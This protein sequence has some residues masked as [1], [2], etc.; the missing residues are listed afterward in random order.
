[1]SGAPFFNR[2]RA[3]GIVRPDDDRWAAG[4]AA[5][6]ARRWNVHPA[7]VRIGFV[8]LTLLG[9]FGVPLYGLG[10]LFLPHPD[11]R[12]HAQQVLLGKVTAGFFGAA[13][14]ILLGAPDIRGPWLALLLL[15]LLVWRLGGQRGH[16]PARGC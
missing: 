5:G 15:G 13:L 14:A 7:A 12:I 8:V 16:G 9:G 11:G 6:L 10:W 4:V 2:I 3:L 1:V